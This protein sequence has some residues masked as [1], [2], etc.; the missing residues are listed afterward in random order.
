MTTTRVI[1]ADESAAD[2]DP[3]PAQAQT[4]SSRERPASE[5][6]NVSSVDG[7]GPK[8]GPTQ[9]VLGEQADGRVK[10]EL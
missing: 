7:G 9:V 1:L 5:G 8:T 3:E 6:E 4:Q 10:D 2:P